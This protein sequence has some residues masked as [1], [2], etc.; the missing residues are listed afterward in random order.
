MTIAGRVYLEF[1]VVDRRYDER[2]GR[3]GGKSV[4]G[5]RLAVVEEMLLCRGRVRCEKMYQ[6]D[7]TDGLWNDTVDGEEPAVVAAAAQ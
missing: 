4:G 2:R 5:G 6:N 1:D 3:W 7:Q